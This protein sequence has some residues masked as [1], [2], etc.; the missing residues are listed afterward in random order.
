[1][2]S[3]WQQLG[4]GGVAFLWW[5]QQPA[6]STVVK[7][8]DNKPRHV[9]IC[10]RRQSIQHNGC[11]RL[12]I[13]RPSFFLYRHNNNNNC[14]S[15][16]T[17]GCSRI[18][19]YCLNTEYS[20]DWQNV[21]LSCHEGCIASRYCD[22]CYCAICLSHLCTL[23]KPRNRVKCHLAGTLVQPTRIAVHEWRGTWRLKICLASF[24]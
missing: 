22:G 2:G 23:L 12:R 17:D 11:K 1:M 4:S 21:N 15:S 8:V 16:N 9:D 14:S 19:V 18:H 5:N 24:S 6:G 3:S 10:T 13:P 20:S 7:S